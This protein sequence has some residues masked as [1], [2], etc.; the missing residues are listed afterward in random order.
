MAE[1]TTTKLNA[2]AHLVLD[3][4]LIRLPHELARKNLRSA[5]TLVERFQ[6]ETNTNIETAQKAALQPSHSTAATVAS[7]DAVLNKAQTLKRKL[8]TLHAEERALQ[9]QQK[10]RLKHLQE[11]Q[12]IPSLVDVKFDRWSKTR[13]DRML[14][15]YML[16]LGYTDSAKMLAQERQIQDLVDVN[17]FLSLG[18]VEKSLRQGRTNEALAWCVENKRALKEADSNLELELRLQQMIEMT[19]NGDTSK[20]IEATLHARKYLGGQQ[21][22]FYGLRAGGLLAYP[23][24]TLTEPYRELYSTARWSYLADLFVGTYEKIFSL[25]SHPLLHIALSAG[26]S[27]L[28]TPACHSAFASSSSNASSTTTSVCPICSTELNEIARNVPYAHHSKSY[29]E[30]DPVVLPNGRIYGRERLMAMNEKLGTPEGR[31]RDPTNVHQE[32]NE[33]ELKKVF[34]S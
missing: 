3:Q 30:S 1:L 5:R 31:I 21:D 28:K 10:S 27:A 13:L 8:E 2:N 4:P 19:R 22:T 18:S 12:E 6:A 7:L 26:L 25:P 32:Y 9:N 14:V 11:L 33:R 23:S 24:N 34:I 29:V 17:A 16:R 15:D 20:L